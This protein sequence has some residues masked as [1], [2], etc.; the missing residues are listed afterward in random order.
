M[1]PTAGRTEHIEKEAKEYEDSMTT[2]PVRRVRLAIKTG[3]ACWFCEEG[4]ENGGR[5]G[6][7]AASGR[8]TTTTRDASCSEV[9]GRRQLPLFPSWEGGGELGIGPFERCGGCGWPA[10]YAL[11]NGRAMY[12]AIQVC[13]TCD[14]F[15]FYLGAAAIQVYRGTP[16]HGIPSKKKF[17][18]IRRYTSAVFRRPAASH[19]WASHLAQPYF[20]LVSCTRH[21]RRPL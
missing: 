21:P 8:T 4:R 19:G 1:K 18:K 3:D 12:R 17:K 9:N 6:I 14:I 20:I 16:R 10:C 2:R 5:G 7:F 13:L 15:Y 11:L